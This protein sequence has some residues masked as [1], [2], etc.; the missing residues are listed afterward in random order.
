MSKP[1]NKHDGTGIIS[2]DPA[3]GILDIYGTTVPSDGASGY[4]TGCTYRKIDGG[5]GTAFY[6]NEGTKA[7]C[8]FNAVNPA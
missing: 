3:A 8:D 4:A 2:Q 6:I 5:D 1:L 7:S